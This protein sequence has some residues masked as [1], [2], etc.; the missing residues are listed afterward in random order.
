VTRHPARRRREAVGQVSC[1]MTP[2][3]DCTFQLIIFFILASQ[4]A[5]ES[6]AKLLL[7]DPANSQAV[8]TA[9]V[10]EPN[11]A[12]VNVVS[13]AGETA[14]AGDAFSGRADRYQIG[15]MKIAIQDVD[16]LA[17][18]L[19][20][21]KAVNSSDD[22]TVEVRADR[23]VDYRDVQPVMLAAAKAGIPKMNITALVDQDQ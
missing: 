14:E 16:L 2:M 15:S 10:D 20:R 4:M 6:L 18:V 1:N 7:A 17:E 21:L 23:R 22:F 5:S 13:L 3:I 8:P 19:T 12:I 9:Q 11:K